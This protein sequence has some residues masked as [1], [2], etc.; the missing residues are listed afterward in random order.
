[1][2]IIN[3]KSDKNLHSKTRKNIEIDALFLFCLIYFPRKWKLFLQQISN[4]I[5]RTSLLKYLWRRTF[6]RGNIIILAE[7]ALLQKLFRD[8][9]A[10]LFFVL[11]LPF[12]WKVH[13]RG[14]F[15]M[16]LILGIFRQVTNIFPPRHKNTS[17][18]TLLVIGY[19]YDFFYR[20]KHGRR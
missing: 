13:W 18:E 19:F 15:L 17:C 14:N 5:L 9:Y 6:S 7:S 16:L 12:L 2:Y 1:M 10:C 8:A 11:W 20:P 4:C 3:Q